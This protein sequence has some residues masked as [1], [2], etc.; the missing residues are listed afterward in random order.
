MR[1]IKPTAAQWQMTD[2][3]VATRLAT[4][5]TTL[6]RLKPP[7]LEEVAAYLTVHPVPDDGYVRSVERDRLIVFQRLY[8][9]HNARCAR[10][11]KELS[12]LEHVVSYR[13]YQCFRDVMEAPSEPKP[14]DTQVVLDVVADGPRADIA[15]ETGGA[16]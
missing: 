12:Q 3:R 10:L 7:T 13:K 16:T 14:D 11:G 6:D 9:N 2:Q 5:Q 1:R 15:N 8:A 4:V